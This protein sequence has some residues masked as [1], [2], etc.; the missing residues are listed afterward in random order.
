M[1]QAALQWS[2][3]RSHWVSS[4]MKPRYVVPEAMRTYLRKSL[5]FFL[6]LVIISPGVSFAALRCSNGTPCPM[7]GGPCC[8]T[9]AADASGDAAPGQSKV[10]TPQPVVASVFVSDRSNP[11]VGCEI[12]D[13]VQRV[14]FLPETITAPPVLAPAGWTSSADDPA[15]PHPLRATPTPYVFHSSATESRATHGLRAPPLSS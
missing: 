9:P 4:G 14:I 8:G 15:A 6:A 10:S 7:A 5:S 2:D 12:V 13:P 11:G 3:A 1:F